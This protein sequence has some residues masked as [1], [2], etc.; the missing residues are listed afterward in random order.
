MKYDSKD[1]RHALLLFS[2]VPTLQTCVIVPVC[3]C[4]CVGLITTVPGAGG[5]LRPADRVTVTPT[6]ASTRTATR[7]ADTVTAR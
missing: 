2:P 5:D 7:P 1:F 6:K 3:V 4:V